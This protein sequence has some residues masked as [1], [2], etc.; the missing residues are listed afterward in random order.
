[1]DALAGST[2]GEADQGGSSI[3]A[4][5]RLSDTTFFSKMEKSKR[6][7]KSKL[8]TE[9]GVRKGNTEGKNFTWWEKEI[10]WEEGTHSL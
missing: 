5:G 7:D 3:R 4:E 2:G 8:K 1:L 10:K 6:A 9:E